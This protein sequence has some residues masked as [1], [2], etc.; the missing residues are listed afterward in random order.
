MY[1]SWL[2]HQQVETMNAIHE[3]EKIFRYLLTLA[4]DIISSN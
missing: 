1:D 4:K 2:A 3:K